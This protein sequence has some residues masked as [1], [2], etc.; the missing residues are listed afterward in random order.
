M[1]NIAENKIQWLKK[2]FVNQKENQDEQK[3]CEVY[4]KVSQKLTAIKRFS[5]KVQLSEVFYEIT[6]SEREKKGVLN[7]CAR[8]ILN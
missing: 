1:Q 6:S 5:W 3:T 8:E 4:H 7:F 2:N